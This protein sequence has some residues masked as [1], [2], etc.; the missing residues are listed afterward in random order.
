MSGF[1]RRT[2]RVVY[3]NPWLR[4]EAHEIVHPNGTP[5]EHGLVS[6][7]P[8]AA[9]VIV[10]GPTTYLTR[11]DRFA[12]RASVLEVVKGGAAPDETPLEAAQRETREEVGI[13]ASSWMPLGI[14]YEI[15]SV[16]E[17]PTHLFLARDVRWTAT[18]MERVETIAT[19]AMPFAD[20]VRTVL[21]GTLTDAVSGV[22]LLRAAYL[23]N[24][25]SSE[26]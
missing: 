23:M 21:E 8:S 24:A 17:H 12:A 13:V 1:I 25:L 4:F 5:G 2:H 26:G 18:A 10:D 15:P 3:E 20:A 22:A 11:Q 6:F 14:A 7:P 9:V 16:V 19:V